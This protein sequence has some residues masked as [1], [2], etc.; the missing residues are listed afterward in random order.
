[1]RIAAVGANDDAGALGDRTAAAGV[2]ADAG[3]SA[4]LEQQVLDDKSFA[5]LR[6]SLARGIEQQLVEHGAARAEC[7][8]HVLD[9]LRAARQGEGTEVERVSLDRRTAGRHQTIQEAPPL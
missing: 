8:V 9:R 5:D 1:S 4:V 7:E 6:A 2:A 3:D